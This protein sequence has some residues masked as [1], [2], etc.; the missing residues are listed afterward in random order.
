LFVVKQKNPKKNLTP[1]PG[2]VPLEVFDLL[3]DIDIFPGEDEATYEGLKLALMAELAPGTPYET[4]LAT[5]LIT[6]EWEAI[7]HRRMRDGLLLAEYRDQAVSVFDAA[8]NGGSAR[9]YPSQSARDLALA[10]VGSD[11]ARRQ[12]AEQELAD[13]G[14]QSAELIAKAYASVSE[15]MEIHERILAETEIRRRRLRADFD[16]LKAARAK[17]VEDAELVEGS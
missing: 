16:R 9:L 2:S 11:R 4:A 14:I 17:P 7:R 15:S 10:L 12:K 6:V 8:E 1:H 3:P 5:N 13:L